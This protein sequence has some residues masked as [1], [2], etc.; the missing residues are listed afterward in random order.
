MTC[1]YENNARNPRA[2]TVLGDNVYGGHL[3][4]NVLLLHADDVD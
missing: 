3:R 1:I 2:E 4:G